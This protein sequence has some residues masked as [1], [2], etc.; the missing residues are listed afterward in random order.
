MSPTPQPDPQL[1]QRFQFSM[2]RMLGAT[3]FL[4]MSLALLTVFSKASDAAHSIVV[5]VG[6][7]GVFL[8]LFTAAVGTWLGGRKGLVIGFG[9][10]VLPS[11][12]ALWVLWQLGLMR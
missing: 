1:P 11:L 9:M 8:G 4:C 7:L 2:A 5:D 10:G 6:L 3:T 12:F